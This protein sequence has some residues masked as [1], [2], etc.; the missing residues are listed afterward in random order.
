VLIRVPDPRERRRARG[1]NRSWMSRWC[2]PSDTNGTSRT[3]LRCLR[4]PCEASDGCCGDRRGQAVPGVW[5][6]RSWPAK[7]GWSPVRGGWPCH[8]KS[9]CPAHG[10][11]ERVITVI[12]DEARRAPVIRGPFPIQR[13]LT[14]TAMTSSWSPRGGCGR[15]RRSARGGTG[16]PGTCSWRPGVRLPARRASAGP[17][18]VCRPGVRRPARRVAGGPACVRSTPIGR[19]R[20]WRPARGRPPLSAAPQCA[21]VRG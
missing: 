18:C 4:G 13:A 14:A 7:A 16:P 3:I 9:I 6:G 8:T 12:T 21:A 5:K 17:A 1:G 20:G 15:L 11:P 10:S 2:R 19:D